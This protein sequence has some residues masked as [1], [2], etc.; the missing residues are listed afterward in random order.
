MGE[1]NMKKWHLISV[2]CALLLAGCAHFTKPPDPVRPQVFVVDGRLLVVNAEP[3][4]FTR[5]GEVT[6]TWH[7]PKGY[8]FDERQGIVIEGRLVR[9]SK[10]QDGLVQQTYVLD[11]KQDE[12]IRCSRSKDGSEFSCL[13]RNRTPGRYKYTIRALDG[14]KALTSLDPWVMND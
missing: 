3:L 9:E 1:N 14:T 2:A 7:L 13:N 10:S 6:I 11:P 5:R 4:V 8:T 12:I